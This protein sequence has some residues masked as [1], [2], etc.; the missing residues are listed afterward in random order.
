MS[1]VIVH[2][3]DCR[4]APETLLARRLESRDEIESVIIVTKWKSGTVI[5]NWSAQPIA[6]VVFGAKV[7][8]QR[9]NEIM[10]SLTR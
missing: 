3:G 9:V 4:L 5:A 6:D 1:D 7:L 10:A 8:E 2:L